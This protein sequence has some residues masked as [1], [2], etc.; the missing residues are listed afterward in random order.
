MLWSI[1]TKGQ[2]AERKMGNIIY[3][4]NRPI[5]TYGMITL[6]IIFNHYPCAHSTDVVG[7]RIYSSRGKKIYSPSARILNHSA[8]SDI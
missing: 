6:P 7:G 5:F 3:F 8:N 2:I 1:T 4:S